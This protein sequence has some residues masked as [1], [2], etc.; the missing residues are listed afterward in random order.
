[1]GD[2]PTMPTT[3][4]AVSTSWWCLCSAT[5]AASADASGSGREA[6]LEAGRGSEAV[7]E[8]PMLSEVAVDRCVDSHVEVSSPESSE[9]E[10][11]PVSMSSVGSGILSSLVSA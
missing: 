3:I 6:V 11:E 4:K 9:S 7:C 5:F 10:S 1:M 2:V 8:G